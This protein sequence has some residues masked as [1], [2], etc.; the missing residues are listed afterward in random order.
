MAMTDRER[1]VQSGWPII[2]GAMLLAA[3]LFASARAGAPAPGSLRH[4]TTTVVP[5]DAENLDCDSNRSLAGYRCA[6][7]D[8]KLVWSSTR[9]LKPYATVQGELVLFSGLFDDPNVAAWLR[10]ARDAHRQ[11]RVTLGCDVRVL[12]VFNSVG[13]RWRKTDRFGL[14]SNLLTARVDHCQIER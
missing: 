8:Q 6:Y 3:V 2:L 7:F 1:F 11:D 4:I 14:E 5:S 10:S 12:G 13:V 9:A